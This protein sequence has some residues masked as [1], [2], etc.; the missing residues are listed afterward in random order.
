MLLKMIYSR[1]QKKSLERLRRH[2][3]WRKGVG[4]PGREGAEDEECLRH[5]CDLETEVGRQG[6]LER[7]L[8]Q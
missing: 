6:S 5:K 1:N 8:L 2:D 4:S 7:K 3:L